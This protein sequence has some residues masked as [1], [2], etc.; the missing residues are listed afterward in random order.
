VHLQPAF[1]TTRTSLEGLRETERLAGQ[2]VT[3]PLYPELT[4][5][6]IARICDALGDWNTD[7]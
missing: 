6:E 2:I 5:P 4:E 3:L 1:K 7:A